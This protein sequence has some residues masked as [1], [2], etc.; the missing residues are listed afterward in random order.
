MWFVITSGH[1]FPI[2]IYH[3]VYSRSFHPRSPFEPR[4]VPD[5]LTAPVIHPSLIGFPPPNKPEPSAT[6]ELKVLKQYCRLGDYAGRVFNDLKLYNVDAPLPKLATDLAKLLGAEDHGGPMAIAIEG[7]T[8]RIRNQGVGIDPVMAK[9]AVRAYA[10]RNQVCHGEAGHLVVEKNWDALA[11]RVSSD[12]EALPE[13]LPEDQIQH[14]TTWRQILHYYRD[15]YIVQDSDEKWQKREDDSIAQIP[16]T[17][18]APG[19]RPISDLPPIVAKAWFSSGHFRADPAPLTSGNSKAEGIRAVCTALHS[20]PES[21]SKKPTSCSSEEPRTIPFMTHL[22]IRKN[23]RLLAA[24]STS[25][26]PTAAAIS[27][28]SGGILRD[29]LHDNK[30]CYTISLFANPLS[31]IPTL[32]LLPLQHCH[33]SHVGPLTH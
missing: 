15:W 25:I 33:S 3:G 17:V 2:Y 19:D 10:A 22:M 13:L 9:F 32:L 12:L 27:R 28:S 26:L 21:P 29:T 14:L 16:A 4:V 1:T 31:P 11:H 6:K 5:D 23:P 30:G 7:A 24:L 8:C 20:T 18:F